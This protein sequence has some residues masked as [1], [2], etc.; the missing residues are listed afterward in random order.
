[1]ADT[2]ARVTPRLSRSARRLQLM[3][4]AKSAFVTQGYHAAAMDDIADRAG[5]SK[6]V[7]YQ[8]FPSKLELYLALL[9]ESADEMVRLVRVALSA[10][11]DNHQRV[12][13]AVA[14][15]FT[16]VADNGQAYRLIFE[17]DLR[18]QLEVE[19]IVERATDDCISAITDTITADT[20]ADV[21]RARLLASGMVGLS[22]VSARY[23]LQ[24]SPHVSRPEAIEL[25]SSLM[26]RGISRFPRQ[27]QP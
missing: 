18:G 2:A 23:W 25:L 24:Q 19:R 26:W 13:N 8:H 4:A 5:V 20:G 14:A 21:E 27:D 1:M 7:L 15:Y 17:S 3:S 16:F 11:M 10:T 12:D 6:P 9:N 22:Q